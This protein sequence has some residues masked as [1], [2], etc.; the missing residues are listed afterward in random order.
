M[1]NETE[2]RI[3]RLGE[4]YLHY[5]LEYKKIKNMNL[6]IYR[7]GRVAVSVPV[8][9]QEIQVEQFLSSY[10]ERI[11]EILNNCRTA[12]R[13]RREI[14]RENKGKVWYLGRWFQKRVIKAD[15]P[16]VRF[17]DDALIVAVLNPQSEK[18]TDHALRKFW[19]EECLR[20][21]SQVLTQQYLHVRPY[22]A[23]MPTLSVRRMKSR[24][25]SCMPQQGKITLNTRLIGAPL[26][27]VEYVAAHELCHLLQPD[28][29]KQ[30][31]LWMDRIMP[32]WRQRKNRLNQWA[33]ESEGAE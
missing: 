28:H 33:K 12:E 3:I 23:Q 1:K 11:R 13:I 14:M 5:T 21:F 22:G 20:L 7:D 8:G 16:F 25:G 29:S 2:D 26:E 19:K 32:D 27:C 17:L 24:W 10:R 15:H 31:Y 9:T 4:E 6:R 18:E 30:F